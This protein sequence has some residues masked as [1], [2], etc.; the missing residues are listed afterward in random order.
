MAL[1]P[2]RPPRRDRTPPAA[3]A[4]RPA[5]AGARPTT[6][7]RG[8]PAP[9]AGSRHNPHPP[10]RSRQ[11]A[12]TRRS[13]GGPRRTASRR[14]PWQPLRHAE[15][16]NFLDHRTLLSTRVNNTVHITEQQVTAMIISRTQYNDGKPQRPLPPS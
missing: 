8:L 6:R 9:T 1:Q 2:A 11:Q 4:T 7:V 10:P 13:R 5:T 14:D 16:T 3:P 15:K 12:A